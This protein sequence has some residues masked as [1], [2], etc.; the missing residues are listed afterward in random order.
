MNT[1]FDKL[2]SPC[3][4]AENGAGSRK[5]PPPG[6]GAGYVVSLDYRYCLMVSEA[7]AGSSET[8]MVSFML[9]DSQNLAAQ[10][11]NSSP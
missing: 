11:M 4:G 10:A 2:S 1:L 6:S 9:L 3:G 7:F 5:N 8:E